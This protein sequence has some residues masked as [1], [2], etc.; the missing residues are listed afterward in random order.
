MCDDGKCISL[1]WRCDGESDC[2]D[3]EDETNCEGRGSVNTLLFCLSN[4]I[5]CNGCFLINLRRASDYQNSCYQRS[6]EII[7][8]NTKNN[9]MGF[10]KSVKHRLEK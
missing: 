9:K 3:S 2:D 10:H 8:N 1:D 4:Y 5:F 6:N 7:I